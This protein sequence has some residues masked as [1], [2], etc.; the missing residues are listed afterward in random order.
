[1]RLLKLIT[2]I[3]AGVCAFAV[4]GARAQSLTTNAVTLSVLQYSQDAPTTNGST[5]TYHVTKAPHNSAQLVQ[6][7]LGPLLTG[8]NLTSAAKLVMI[9]NN[10]SNSVP[11][12]AV[13]DGTNFYDLS[14]NGDSVMTLGFPGQNRITSGT[15]INNSTQQNRTQMQLIS[16]SYDD[17]GLTN[18][19]NH[20]TLKFT[21]EGLATIIE[22]DTA[23]TG[24][25]FTATV[26]AKATLA[27]EGASGGNQD[28]FVMTATMSVSGSGKVG[29]P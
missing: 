3:I 21:L 7:E 15:Q 23:E 18:G 17:T 9:I 29:G 13:I 6:Q 8:S 5:I 16:V 11:T 28:P 2:S 1:M 20:G 12:F 10:T 19:A 14:T 24:G 27:G 26:K 4:C 25:F 22:T